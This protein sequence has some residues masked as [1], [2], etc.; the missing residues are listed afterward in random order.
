MC[1]EVVES[2]DAAENTILVLIR[3]SDRMQPARRY[4]PLDEVSGLFRTL[5]DVELNRDGILAFANRYGWLGTPQ[6]S[7]SDPKWQA[8]GQI[9]NRPGESWP[10]WENAIKS[11]RLAIRL[12][13][14]ARSGDRAGLAQHVQWGG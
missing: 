11:L 8:S 13:E 3:Q 14:M 10:E 9:P 6:F 4:A 5:A 1:L 7:V 2:A 12:W